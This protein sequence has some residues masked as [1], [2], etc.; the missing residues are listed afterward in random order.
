MEL[1]KKYS[2]IILIV[3]IVI[4][5]S[6]LNQVLIK[7]KQV[8]EQVP[9][10]HF[11]YIGKNSTDP[12]WEAIE[13]GVKEAAAT[14]N[15]VIED[16]TPKFSSIE[17]QYKALDI[18]VLSRVDG[19]ITYGY[20]EA[21]FTEKID[22]AIRMRIPLVTV[23]S[24]NKESKRSVYIG[25][26]SY[27]LGEEAADLLVEATSGHGQILL[28]RNSLESGNSLDEE[29]RVDG[30]TN[31]LRS[32]RTL[33]IIDAEINSEKAETADAVISKAFHQN[34]DIKAIYTPNSQDTI[35]AS[36]Y[37]VNKNLVGQVVVVGIGNSKEAINY[38]KKGILYGTVM[39][40]P[41][42]MGYKSVE[43]LIQVSENKNISV[44]ADTGLRINTYE[45]ILS[46]EA[47]KEKQK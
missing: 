18:S 8:A 36:K 33:E 47:D 11:Y 30:F 7:E 23:E 41:Y 21:T 15:V 25:T 14:F 32:Y 6:I 16:A 2:T 29:L 35:K 39:S 20:S 38:I 27:R 37:I 1:I 5:A 44:V 9:T 12:Y 28:L 4:F 42:L 17:E 45:S 24:D 10:Y 22:Q 19:I 13:K 46:E 31:R 43:M 3:L 40:D 34:P 26:S